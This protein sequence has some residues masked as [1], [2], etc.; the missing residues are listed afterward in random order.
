MK[1]I[2]G[3]MTMPI[4]NSDIE[5]HAFVFDMDGTLVYSDPKIGIPLKKDG[6]LIRNLSANEYSSYVRKEGEYFDY[7]YAND[8]EVFLAS[9]VATPIFFEI[10]SNLDRIIYETGSRCELYILT[11]RQPKME[12]AIHKFFVGHGIKT[13]TRKNTIGVPAGFAPKLK[14]DVLK[15]LVDKHGYAHFFDDDAKNIEHAHQ[16]PNVYARKV[17][18]QIK[19]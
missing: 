7:S 3:K 13:L 17:K 2:T 8:P 1:E 11:A 15:T 6:I 4:L 18:C 14:Q 9:S 19:Y 5:G 10:F 12:D 16:L